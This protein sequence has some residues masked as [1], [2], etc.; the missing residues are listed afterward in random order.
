VATTAHVALTKNLKRAK[1]FLDLHE[2]TQQGPGTP[3]AKRRELPRGAV[4]FA[5]GALDA[6]LSEVSAEV[7]LGQFEKAILSGKNRDVLKEITRQ[8]PTL[9]LE[10]ALAGDGSDRREIV[11]T[12]VTEHFYN[13]VSNHG[14]K[15]VAAA[16]E[17]M[18]GSAQTAWQ[19]TAE[20]GEAHAAAD[21]DDWTAKRHAIVHQ[22][23]APKINRDPAR[24]C[25]IL[26]GRIGAA[27]DEIAS[28]ALAD[29]DAAA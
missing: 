14:A 25:V 27:V 29:A 28:E 2:G 22:G 11:R 5:V 7:M 1:H 6:Y 12:T 21:L 3:D 23:K 8:H 17:R 9:A 20:L 15:A 13:Q 4:V 18:N 26:I 19:R 16:I 10:A 24:T